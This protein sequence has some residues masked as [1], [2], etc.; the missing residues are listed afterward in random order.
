M[1]ATRTPGAVVPMFQLA[2]LVDRQRA[3]LL[4]VLQDG[5]GAGLVG[6]AHHA[7]ASARSA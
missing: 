4:Q 5:D 2:E 3:V 6:G 7:Q 1:L